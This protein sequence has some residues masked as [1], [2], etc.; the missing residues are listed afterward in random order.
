MY[1][2]FRG[3]EPFNWQG[4]VQEAITRRKAAGLTQ[5]KH[6]ALA[7]VSIPTML[8]FE[9]AATT[10]SIGKVIDILKVVSLVAETTKLE[11][12]AQDA[13]RRWSE[14]TTALPKD[15][16]AIHKYGHYNFSYQIL[17]KMKQISASELKET[18]RE[19][20]K[21]KY[22]GWTPFWIAE[23]NEDLKPYFRGNLLECW[24]NKQDVAEF[25]DF[26]QV[27]PKGLAH[28][29]RGYNEDSQEHI[30]PN[31]IFYTSTPI[32]RAL[33][34][35]LHAARLARFISKD[36]SNAQIEM[37]GSFTGLAGRRLEIGDGLPWGA[38]V[39]KQNDMLIKAKI[40]ASDV[41]GESASRK[42][43]VGVLQTF[44]A[45]LYEQF[46]GAQL[47]EQAIENQLNKLIYKLPY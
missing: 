41:W 22:S 7:D 23:N 44:L 35:I 39:C 4:L 47:S 30:V 20:S 32:F 26:W 21:V 10:L 42:N 2:D 29:H 14:L 33:E 13:E 15:S 38:K 31:S 9:K 46:D 1:K 25:T 3:I 40:M 11:T 34:V 28:L 43:L 37:L 24:L 19:V 8:D 45:P 27:S 12:F 36:Y 18:L 5:K 6:A 17:E 16:P